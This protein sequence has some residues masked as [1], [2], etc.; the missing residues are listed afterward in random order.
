[1]RVSSAASDPTYVREADR[2]VA[3][4]LC[5]LSLRGVRSYS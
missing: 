1:M 2:Q 3:E 5:E 4:R